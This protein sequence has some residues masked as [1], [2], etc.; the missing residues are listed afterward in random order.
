MLGRVWQQRFAGEA[1]SATRPPGVIER[2]KI[3]FISHNISP[4]HTTPLGS[5]PMPAS[6][7]V[8]LK[9][10]RVCGW[11]DERMGLCY[12]QGLMKSVECEGHAHLTWLC[13]GGVECDGVWCV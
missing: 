7:L 12:R 10:M 13:L 3:A 11:W 6:V 8:A 1:K 9:G 4:S 2:S 5:W